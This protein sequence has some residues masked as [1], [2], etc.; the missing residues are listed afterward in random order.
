MIVIVIPFV[1]PAT[2]LLQQ[3]DLKREVEELDF[4]F[5]RILCFLQ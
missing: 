4:L 3:V 5:I 2:R 1:S